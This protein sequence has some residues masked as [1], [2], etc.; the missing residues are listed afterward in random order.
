MKYIAAL[1]FAVI[2]PIYYVLAAESFWNLPM[3]ASDANVKA[4]FEVDSTWH[5]V[6]GT[7]SSLTGKIWLE[8]PADFSSVRATLHI[9]VS[10]FDTQR[11]SRDRRMREVMAADTYPEVVFELLGTEG[12]CSPQKIAVESP[13]PAK[14]NGRLTIR[15]T[16]MDVL[17]PVNVSRRAHAFV[18]EGKKDITWADYGVEDPSIL[19][20]KVDPIVTVNFEVTLGDPDAG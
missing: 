1:M 17:L 10:A 9:P 14:L 13:C 2:T 3:Q 8:N 15:G 5:M 16:S 19:I 7:T 11:K 6:H 12:L 4:A 20:A 18:I